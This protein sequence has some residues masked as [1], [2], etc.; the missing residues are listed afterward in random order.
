MED[1]SEVKKSYGRACLNPKFL[2]RFYEIF[3]G[4]HP[5][6]KP[7]FAKTDF[8]KQKEAL[9]TGLAMLLAHLE[10]KPTGTMTLDRI[11]E[12]H[13]KKNMNIDPNL[14]QYWIDSLVKAVKE[15]DPQFTPELERGWEK[16]C[17][18]GV[19]YIV[20]KYES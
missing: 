16:V 14:Y 19:D 15:I 12:S 4:S 1:L 6:I 5:R 7:L 9:R 2:D 10:G 18:A 13:S 8:K 11:G 17:R 3:L 20:S